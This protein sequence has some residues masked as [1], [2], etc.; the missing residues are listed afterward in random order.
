M[1]P[2]A[3]KVIVKSRVGRGSASGKKIRWQNG[4]LGAVEASVQAAYASRTVSVIR[5]WSDFGGSRRDDW[6]APGSVETVQS[7]SGKKSRW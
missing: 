7:A 6:S 1:A 3:M 2:G 5:C 4:D